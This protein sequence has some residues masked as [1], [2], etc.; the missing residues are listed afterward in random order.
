MTYEP[1]YEGSPIVFG[2]PGGASSAHGSHT[3]KARAG[4]HLPP[5]LLSTG[6]NVFQ[7]LGAAFT[8]LLFDAQD[9]TA[10]AFAQAA[11]ALQ[12]PLKIVRDSSEQARRVY[13]ANFIL[14]RPDRYIAWAG[15]ALPSDPE[16]LLAKS[17]ARSKN[18]PRLQ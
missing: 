3:F 5:Q 9:A 8:L 14:V 11:K 17:I 1:H 12:L 18:N 2:P 4:H 7:E 16:S 13:E 6:R 15:D 10:A